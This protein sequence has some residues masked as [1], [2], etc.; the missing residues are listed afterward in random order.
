MENTDNLHNIN[1]SANVEILY[2]FLL[3]IE[4]LTPKLMNILKGHSVLN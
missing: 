4:D 1:I 3:Y 2:G